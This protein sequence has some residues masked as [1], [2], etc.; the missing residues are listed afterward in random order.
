MEKQIELKDKAYGIIVNREDKE[1]IGKDIEYLR[2]E[3]K[4]LMEE[5]K[6]LME[7]ENLLMEREKTSSIH[8]HIYKVTNYLSTFLCILSIKFSCKK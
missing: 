6:L 1:R 7:K 2:E 8:I 3:N 4:L 5:K